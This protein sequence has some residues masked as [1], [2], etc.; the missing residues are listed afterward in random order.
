MALKWISYVKKDIWEIHLDSLPKWKAS[1]VRFLRVVM[2]T[3]QGF[4]KSQIQQGASSLTYY[5]LLAFVPVLALL[6]G[7]ARGFQFEDTLQIW[8]TRQFFDQ[9]DV[10]EKVFDFAKISLNQASQGVIAGVGIALLLWS[11]IKI[12][13]NLEHVMNKIW[14]T[15]HGRSLS[16]KFTDYLAMLFLCPV[17]I[18]LASGI[19]VYVSTALTAITGEGHF[20]ATF[21]GFLLPFLNFIPLFLTCIL[22]AFLY[23]FMPSTRVKFSAAIWAGVITGIIYQLVQMLYLY[24]Q[25]GV[26]SYNAVYGTFAALPLFLVWIHLSWVIVLVGAKISFALQNVNAFDFSAEKGYLSHRFRMILS[27]RIMHLCIKE[28]SIGKRA[29]SNIEISNR[30]SIP[31]PLASQLLFELSDAELLSE[32]NRDDD[33][34]E[35]YQPAK[36]PDQLTIKEIL[37]RINARGEE[38]SLP[39]SQTLNL[40]LKSLDQFSQAIEASDGNILLKDI[41]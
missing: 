23:I 40:I 31:L 33:S 25:I 39:K 19:T 6:I 1:W 35:G 26:T 20:L 4:A 27:L 9:K 7:I 38:V 8:L 34:N 24:F 30:L 5:T 22:F 32:V 37:D 16:K 10:I 28:F 17:I 41:K 36:S 15:R 2:L 12:L 11:A 18:F 21:R 3:G 13:L 29:P 14:E